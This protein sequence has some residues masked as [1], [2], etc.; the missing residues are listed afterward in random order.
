MA[1][2]EKKYGYGHWIA[3]CMKQVKGFLWVKG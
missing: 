3:S 2:A 1:C